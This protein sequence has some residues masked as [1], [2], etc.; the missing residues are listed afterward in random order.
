MNDRLLAVAS[1]V[2]GRSVIDIGCDH[3]YLSIY[4]SQ[5]GINCLATDISDHCINK[6]I[7]NFNKYNV[8]IDTKVTDGLNGI[9]TSL[10]DTIIISGMGTHTILKILKAKELT[11]TLVISSN[12]NIELLR[13]EITKLGYYIDNELYTKENNQKYIIIRFKKGHKEYTDL[14]YLIGPILK[15][16]KQYINDS[17]NEYKSIIDR[18]GSNDPKRTKKLNSY[19]DLLK[20]DILKTI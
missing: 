17:I 10:Y 19:I 14:D 3:G 11:D 2:D 6:A 16:N 15:Y 9:D 18:I 12:N 4:L 13:K 7:N 5:K 8:S 1:L 20:K